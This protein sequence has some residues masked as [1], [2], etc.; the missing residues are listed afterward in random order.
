MLT[1]KVKSAGAVVF[2]RENEEIFYLLLHYRARHWDLPKGNIE[3]GEKIRE[4]ARRE[5]EEETGIKDLKFIKGFKE[6]IEYSFKSFPKKSKRRPE[7]KDIFKT[8]VFLLAE[9]GTK[10][11]KISREHTGYKWLCYE[12]ALRQLT[13]E[14]AK[15]VLKKADRHLKETAEN[16]SLRIVPG[17]ALDTA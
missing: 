10:E 13:F 5:I 12:K 2:R 16:S 8:V 6:R 14:K 1:Q 3:S 11:I 4:T 9:T 7:G 17:A 15:K